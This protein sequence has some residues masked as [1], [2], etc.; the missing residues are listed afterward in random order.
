MEHVRVNRVV[1]K[2][3]FLTLEVFLARVR[4][5]ELLPTSLPHLPLQKPIHRELVLT[6]RYEEILEKVHQLRYVTAWDIS[7][8][9]YT[10]SSI[11]HVRE[12]LSLLA[13]N[14]DYAE[15]HYLFRFP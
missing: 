2:T 14:K 7:R 15:R 5:M 1:R 12:I 3:A 8:M 9:F 10:P 6:K 4:A 13:G 11:N